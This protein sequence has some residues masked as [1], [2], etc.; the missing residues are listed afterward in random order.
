MNKTYLYWF[1]VVVATLPIASIARGDAWISVELILTSQNDPLAQREWL[2]TLSSA[3]ADDVRVV[4]SGRSKEPSLTQ[5]GSAERPRY[6]LIGAVDSRGQLL[7]PGGRFGQRD[8]SKL[9]KYFESLSADGTEGVTAE[10]GK[11]G[12][13]KNQ[14]QQVTDDLARPLGF[15]TTGIALGDVLKQADQGTKLSLHMDD[16]VWRQVSKAQPVPEEFQTLTTG[17]ALAIM[18]KREGLVLVP[19]KPQG[20]EVELRIERASDATGDSWPIG[21]KPNRSP[22][23]LAPATA[24][25]INAEV[26]GFTLAEAMKSIEPRL[27][28]PVYWDHATMQAKEID[29]NEVNVRLARQRTRL[30]RVA[31]RL[32]FQGR[33]RG[34]ILVDEAGTPFYWI[35]R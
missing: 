19:T 15:A 20:K 35:S 4:N 28:I 34:D 7:L 29:P 14:T 30:G 18:L 11:F 25:E 2:E 23:E 12:L 3:G 8:V 22:S 1:T 33:L 9:R 24:E 27:G 31:D 21:W 10:R 13:T 17:T 26:E 5:T 6:K 32:L 16:Q